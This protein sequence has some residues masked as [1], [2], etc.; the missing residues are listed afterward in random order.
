MDMKHV[1]SLRNMHC[2]P[3]VVF[4]SV[5][6]IH[7]HKGHIARAVIYNK[8]QQLQLEPQGYTTQHTSIYTIYTNVNT[9]YIHDIFASSGWVEIVFC[10]S[11]TADMK[12]A[13]RMLTNSCR[14]A[15]HPAS[16]LLMR[17]SSFVREWNELATEAKRILGRGKNEP[18]G[19]VSI[20]LEFSSPKSVSKFKSP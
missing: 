13:W 9:I 14:A 8:T 12:P 10:K 18:R 15:P 7:I 3:F 11:R 19:G 6:H 17:A 1:E 2:K 5:P 16:L 4:P 20:P